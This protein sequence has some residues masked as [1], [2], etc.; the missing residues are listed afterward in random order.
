MRLHLRDP[1]I[2]R[3]PV[4]GQEHLHNSRVSGHSGKQLAIIV[5]PFTEQEA[6]RS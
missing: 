6:L 2:T 5:T 4:H 1:G 3:G